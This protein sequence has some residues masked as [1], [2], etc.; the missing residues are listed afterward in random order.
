MVPMLGEREPQAPLWNYRVNLD[1]RVCSDHPLR[2]INGVL[3]LGF[4]RQGSRPHLGR[5]GNKSV[6]NSALRRDPFPFE[7]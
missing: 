2:R 7:P 5:R 6:S 4:V 3:D 1:K